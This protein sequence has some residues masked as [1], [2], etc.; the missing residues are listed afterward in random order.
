MFTGK[1]I[2]V[3]SPTWKYDTKPI[4]QN[5]T[6]KKDDLPPLSFPHT[7]HNPMSLM[8]KNTPLK[9]VISMN[10]SRNVLD[11]KCKYFFRSYMNY[12]TYIVEV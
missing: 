9:Q 4:R 10:N 11:A 5:H 6:Y 8:T 3:D 12:L 1:I 7:K 2:P